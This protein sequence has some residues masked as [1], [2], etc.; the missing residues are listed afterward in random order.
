MEVCT[1]LDDYGSVLA[2]TQLP[3][4]S[5]TTKALLE[6]VQMEIKIKKVLQIIIR[7]E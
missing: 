4:D 5:I 7:F 6:S 1:N 2:N 3:N